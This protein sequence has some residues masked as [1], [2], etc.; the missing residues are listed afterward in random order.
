MKI[1]GVRSVI[2][3]PA[4]CSMLCGR[5]GRCHGREGRSRGSEGRRRGGVGCMYLC[6]CL[7]FVLLLILHARHKYL[8]ALTDLLSKFMYLFVYSETEFRFS[9]LDAN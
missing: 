4:H 3:D 7:C 6:V 2:S 1:S 5:E 8:K 9:Q